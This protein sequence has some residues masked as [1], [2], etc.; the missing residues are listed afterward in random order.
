MF[1]TPKKMILRSRYI[2]AIKPF[3]GKPQIKIITGI[4]RSGKSTVLQLLKNELLNNGVEELAP[5]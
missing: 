3:I 2:D 1:I 4:R 5:I